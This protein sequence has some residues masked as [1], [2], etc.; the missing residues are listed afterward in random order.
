MADDETNGTGPDRT[1]IDPI[2]S[3]STADRPGDPGPSVEDA[4][5]R[6][7]GGDPLAADLI[8]SAAIAHPHRPEIHA[9]E[10]LVAVD[11]EPSL[12]RARELAL[13]RRDRQHIAIIAEHVHGHVE[14]CRLLA[15]HH[16]AEFPDDVIISWTVSRP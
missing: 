11:P 1:S 10:A 14:R 7:M 8:R 3:A 15:R 13:T 4:A 5:Q 16:L 12:T 6:L 2:T 9:M